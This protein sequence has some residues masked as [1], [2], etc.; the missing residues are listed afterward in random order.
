MLMPLEGPS[1]GRHHGREV[2]RRFFED[3]YAE[4]AE[5]VIDVVDGNI[6][7]VAFYADRESVL[8]GAAR[9]TA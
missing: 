4:W 6:S 3:F 1:P 9:S 5:F 7:G 2:I 8:E